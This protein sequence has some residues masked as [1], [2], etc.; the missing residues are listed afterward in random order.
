MSQRIPDFIEVVLHLRNRKIGRNPHFIQLIL[1][2][3]QLF[4]NFFTLNMSNLRLVDFIDRKFSLCWDQIALIF[5]FL[6]A[7]S[8]LSIKILFR[9][10]QWFGVL[11][12]SFGLIHT[13]TILSFNF[14][15]NILILK[16]MGR[17]GLEL[18]SLVILDVIG[19]LFWLGA[20]S[21]GTRTFFLF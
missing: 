4:V 3:I 1:Y 12:A 21:R 6:C 14:S 5:G 18:N 8:F 20:R 10:F 11:P 15:T 17:L 19:S 9:S 7:S 13:E 2:C 16:D